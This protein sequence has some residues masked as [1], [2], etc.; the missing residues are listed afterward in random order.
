MADLPISKLPAASTL[1]GSELVPLTQSGVTKMAT[2]S[3]LS[4]LP[5]LALS[6]TPGSSLVG[7]TNPTYTTVQAA[8]DWAVSKR[9]KLLAPAVGNPTKWIPFNDAGTTRYIP[10]W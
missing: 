8:L 2:G 10:A 6:A 5:L 3:Q 4:G 1:T 7:Y 9:E